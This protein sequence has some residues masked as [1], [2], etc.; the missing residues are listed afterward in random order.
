MFGI[1]TTSIIFTKAIVLDADTNLRAG[2]ALPSEDAAV[3]ITSAQTSG[4]DRKFAERCWPVFEPK[5]SACSMNEIDWR[6]HGFAGARNS[7]SC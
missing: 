6:A 3:V 5:A 4:S 7:S 1:T 2:A